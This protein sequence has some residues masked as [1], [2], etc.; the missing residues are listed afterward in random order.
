MR[1]A[2]ILF[3]FIFSPSCIFCETPKVWSILIPTLEKRESL[4]QRIYKKLCAQIE[5]NN[6]QEQIEICVLR[7]N[8]EMSIG[9]KRN[10]LLRQSVGQYVCFVDDDDDVHDQYIHLIYD[11]LTTEKPDCVSLVGIITFDGNNP[12]KFIHSINYHSYFE[13]ENIYYRPPNHLNPMLR[14]I[15]VQF[16]FPDSFYGEDTDWAMQICNAN[17]LKKES[18][19]D[20]PYYFYLYNTTK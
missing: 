5:Q 14:T 19:V 4:F 13:K 10:Q 17:L 2:L 11:K 12:K 20:E 18:V 16:A 7:D 1:S 3:L 9:K 8:G 15:A 6:L